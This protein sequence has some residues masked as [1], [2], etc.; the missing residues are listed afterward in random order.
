LFPGKLPFAVYFE[1]AGE[2][3]S[4]LSNLR[5]G[6]TAL[7]AGIDFPALPHNLSLTVEASEWQNGWYVHGI[8]R[9]G[10][11][12]E[13]RV[14]GHWGADWRAPGDGVGARGL[15]ARVGWQPKLGGLLEGTYRTLDNELYTGQAYEH[16]TYVEVRYS[17]PWQQFFAGAELSLGRDA[18][19]ESFSRLTGFVRF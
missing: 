19:G 13:G 17:F 14:I 8:Y 4:T 12:N 16:A 9:D 15:M 6:N 1:Y 3:T 10:L 2:D 11:R 5:L 7:S 18:F